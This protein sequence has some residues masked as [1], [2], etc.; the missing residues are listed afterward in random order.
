MKINEIMKPCPFCGKEVR[1]AELNCDM[2]GVTS[3]RVECYCGADVQIDSD[4]Y[5]FDWNGKA[6]RVGLS[7]I[8][9]WNRR[10]GHEAQNEAMEG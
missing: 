4:D 7:A 6:H 10:D 9:K 3:L 8:E 1:L 5:I 2:A